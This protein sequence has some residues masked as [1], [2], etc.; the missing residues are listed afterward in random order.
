MPAT[1][2]FFSPKFWRNSWGYCTL[3]GHHLDQLFES[4]V[5]QL[6]FGFFQSCVTTWQL[7]SSKESREIRVTDASA[8]FIYSLF[9]IGINF[10]R[11]CTFLITRV[12]VF[13]CLLKKNT[14]SRFF[15]FLYMFQYAMWKFWSHFEM[16]LKRKPKR[17]NIVKV[18]VIKQYHNSY[19]HKYIV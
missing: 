16:W 10:P 14:F 17:P 18:Q 7:L 19:H 5:H 1:W 3:Y 4:L 12:H 2:R 8:F 13:V 15:L 11:V 6:H 9:L